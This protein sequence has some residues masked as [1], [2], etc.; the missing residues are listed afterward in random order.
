MVKRISPFHCAE[1]FV[2]S[3]LWLSC[4]SSPSSASRAQDAPRVGGD[5]IENVTLSQDALHAYVSSDTLAVIAQDLTA[6]FTATNEG[7]WDDLLH[8]FPMHKKP[9]DTTFVKSSKEALDH[10]TE[11]GVKNRTAAAEIVYASPAFSD[12]D[13]QVV[14]LNM[15]LHHFVEFHPQ[16]DGPRPD[17]MKGMVESNYGKGNA[18][19]NEAPLAPGDT[20]PLRYWEVTGLNRIWAVSHIDSAHWCFLPPNFNETGA[21]GMMG[22]N[23]MVEALRH[24]RANDP[25][26]DQ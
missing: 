18:V 24:R 19:Y 5:M 2:L 15:Q 12:G 25:T 17:G 6:Y 14:L 13:Q 16:Y 21:A 23:A 26:A 20:I 22:A 9:G 3:C 8:H 4:S 10:W 7:R 1:L 11:R